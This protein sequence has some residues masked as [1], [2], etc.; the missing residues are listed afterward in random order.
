MGHGS[1]DLHATAVLLADLQLVATSPLSLVSLFT[2][3]RTAA[4][5]HSHTAHASDATTATSPQR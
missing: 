3:T 1:W 5:G 4:T 2:I